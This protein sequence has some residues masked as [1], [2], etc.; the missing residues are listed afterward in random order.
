MT[1]HLNFSFKQP[2]YGQ[3]HLLSI[4]AFTFYTSFIAKIN[5]DPEVWFEHH[6]AANPPSKPIDLGRETTCKG[7]CYP[8]PPSPFITTQPESWYLFHHPMTGGRLSRAMHYSKG[9][10][11]VH[12][13]EYRTGCRRNKHNRWQCGLILGS[14]LPKSGILPIDQSIMHYASSVQNF[15]LKWEFNRKNWV[16][17]LRSIF[18]F[19]S[20]NRS[21][22]SLD[23]AGFK[24][25]FGLSSKLQI[26]RTTKSSRGQLPF[27]F[28]HTIS[29]VCWIYSVATA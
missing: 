25:S 28:S 2:F 10:Q 29:C 7:Y 18:T 16:E 13:V 1:S 11:P 27:S 26:K 8:H 21:V 5:L 22:L 6:L 12:K 15:S 9:V 19:V 20:W 4:T 24:L 17:H 14:I 3:W 23:F